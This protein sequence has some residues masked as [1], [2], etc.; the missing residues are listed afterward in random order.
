MP[1]Q[2]ALASALAHLSFFSLI[3][4]FVFISVIPYEILLSVYLNYSSLHLLHYF[5]HEFQDA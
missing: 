3:S 2:I 4:T 5:N 1:L